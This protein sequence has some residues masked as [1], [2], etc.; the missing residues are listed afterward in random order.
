MDFGRNDII[1]SDVRK[2]LYHNG[3]NLKEELGNG[4]FS[5]VYR[6]SDKQYSQD[7]AVKII[8]FADDD[9]ENVEKRN[10]LSKSYEAEC[11]ALMKFYHPNI[12]SIFKH[13]TT[14]K[15]LIMVLEYCSGGSLDDYIQKHGPIP[16]PLLYD[17]C[18]QLISA[19]QYI[20]SKN[21]AHRDI[22]PANI[23]LDKYSRLK[24]ADF[25]LA[26]EAKS[27]KIQDAG[28][29]LSYLP[30][31]IARKGS[32]DPKL[33]DIWSLG[34][35]FYQMASGSLPWHPLNVGD[36]LNAIES[37]SYENN[38][39]IPEQFKP[40][41]F[42]MLKIDPKQ[43]ITL[44]ALSSLE[45][46]QK[47]PKNSSYNSQA[48]RHSLQLISTHN[49]IMSSNSKVIERGSNLVQRKRNLPASVRATFADNELFD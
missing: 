32:Y 33:S 42:Q 3:Y 40:V 18:N 43:R 34:I 2:F 20:H 13:F 36:L 16:P 49:Q 23:F 24:L 47:K 26:I 38:E 15:Y 45:L 5:I 21:I 29:S 27:Q 31:E 30:P 4:G 22:K 28:G 8:R 25:G 44:Q 48:R 11:Q 10:E 39:N 14:D 6:V 19:L 17:L 41:V 1:L 12:I 7:F 35:T 9:D 37:K 46:F